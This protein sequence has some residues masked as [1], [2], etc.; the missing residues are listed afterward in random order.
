[1]AR[2]VARADYGAGVAKRCE[3]TGFETT[4]ERWVVERTFGWIGRYRGLAK[5][6][7]HYA[8]TTAAFD[9]DQ[10]A[11]KMEEMAS[12]VQRTCTKAL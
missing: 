9:S 7:D 11:G 5:G 12:L 8:G 1:M 6:F 2:V 3:A 10:T 4:P